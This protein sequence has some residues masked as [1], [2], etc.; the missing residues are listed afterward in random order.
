[1]TGKL[2]CVGVGPGDPELIT[3]KALKVL[4]QSR[5]IFIPSAGPTSKK[6]ALQVVESALKDKECNLLLTTNK[7]S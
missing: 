5:V 3:I 2:Y 1:M 6:L 4:E 7:N